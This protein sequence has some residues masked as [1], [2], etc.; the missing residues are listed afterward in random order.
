MICERGD[1][2]IPLFY[3][4][5]LRGITRFEVEKMALVQILLLLFSFLKSSQTEL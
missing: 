2:W 4:L 3:S 1:K 5:K